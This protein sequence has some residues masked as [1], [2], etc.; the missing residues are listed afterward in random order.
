MRERIPIEIP[1]FRRQIET[2]EF[3]EDE[4]AQIK[5]FEAEIAQTEI[6]CKS[7]GNW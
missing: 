6:Q 2:G 4:R 5:S 7:T 3:D 1:N